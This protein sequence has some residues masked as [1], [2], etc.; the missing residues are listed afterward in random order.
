RGIAELNTVITLVESASASER[1]FTALIRTVDRVLDQ[2]FWLTGRQEEAL[3]SGLHQQLSTIRSTAE[4]VLDEYEKVQSIRAQTETAISEVAEAQST[5]MRDLKPDSWKAPDQFVGF[6][7]RLREHRG[8][9]RTLNDRR[10][11]DKARIDTL[12]Q[13]LA[14][15][16]EQIGRASC[17]ESVVISEVATW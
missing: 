11:A 9:V 12:E 5:L 6:L 8:R 13:E 3:F 10:Y 15:S 17:R 16:E 2:F 14:E 1:H 4:L 7:A